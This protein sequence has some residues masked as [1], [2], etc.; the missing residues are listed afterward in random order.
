M[1][2]LFVC[3]FSLNFTCCFYLYRWRFCFFWWW[4]MFG[5]NFFFFKNI[6]ALVSL[7]C[8]SLISWGISQQGVFQKDALRHLVFFKPD[9][10]LRVL[11]GDF[12]GKEMRNCV[13]FFLKE[14]LNSPSAFSKRSRTRCINNC[15]IDPYTSMCDETLYIYVPVLGNF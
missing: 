7:V 14:F 4:V 5:H 1:S 10:F 6:T 11:K 15:K 9:A 12:L 8:L 2:V 13:V 3:L